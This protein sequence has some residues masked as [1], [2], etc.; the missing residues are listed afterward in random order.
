MYLIAQSYALV[1]MLEISRLTLTVDGNEKEFAISSGILHFNK[2]QAYILVDAIEGKE[3]IDLERAKKS[4]E[5]ARKRLERKDADTSI[6][7]AE[8]SLQRAL[9]RIRIK[10]G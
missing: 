6:R 2:N 7:R 5:R 3:E 10:N 9:N 8:V 4:A 1:A